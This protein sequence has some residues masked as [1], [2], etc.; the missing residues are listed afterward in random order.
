MSHSGI[1]Y[2]KISSNNSVSFVSNTL[3]FIRRG[4]SCRSFRSFLRSCRFLVQTGLQ[5]IGSQAKLT[6]LADS[7]GQL[8]RRWRMGREVAPPHSRTPGP[9]LIQKWRSWRMMTRRT[10]QEQ[11]EEQE[12]LRGRGEDLHPRYPVTFPRPGPSCVAAFSLRAL[13]CMS[14]RSVSVL[15]VI[16]GLQGTAARRGAQGKALES[17]VY[18]P[19]M[20]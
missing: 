9:T 10:E 4:R 6:K 7:R 20:S 14:M 2:S 15:T 8:Q 3:A 11:R 17:R 1:R 13:C 19:V 5:L 18:Y 16:R 12:D